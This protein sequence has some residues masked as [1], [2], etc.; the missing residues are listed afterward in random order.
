MIWISAWLGVC[1][2]WYVVTEATGYYFGP[3]WATVSAALSILF[4][5]ASLF[6]FAGAPEPLEHLNGY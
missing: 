5:V 2:V 3:G 1:L 4:A 6:Y